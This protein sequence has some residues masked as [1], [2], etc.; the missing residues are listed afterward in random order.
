MFPTLTISDEHFQCL[1]KALINLKRDLLIDSVDKNYVEVYI[2][3]NSTIHKY[4][5]KNESWTNELYDYL[6]ECLSDAEVQTIMKYIDPEN[7]YHQE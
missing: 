2:S 7:R 5:I 6:R 4:K 1:G 3:Q